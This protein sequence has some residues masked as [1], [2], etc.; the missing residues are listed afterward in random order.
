MVDL[1]KVGVARRGWLRV[2]MVA[3]VSLVR[4]GV[5]V[6]PMVRGGRRVVH[7]EGAWGSE[8]RGQDRG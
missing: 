2:R 4:G 3:L 8:R 7:R 5:G 1:E 6:L